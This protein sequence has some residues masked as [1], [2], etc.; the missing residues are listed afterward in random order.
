MTI[1]L[2]THAVIWFITNDPKL[3]LASKLMIEDIS[4]NCFVSLASYWE[5]SIKYSLGRLEL[6]TSIERIFE[7]VEESG[8]EI[9]PISASHI[10]TSSKLPFH[11]RDPFDRLLIGQAINEQ[12]KLMS[13]DSQFSNYQVDLVWKI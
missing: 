2:D 13:V 4:H 1:L 12:M 3:P 9:L 8:F 7:I 11:H 10:L 6:N 5:M